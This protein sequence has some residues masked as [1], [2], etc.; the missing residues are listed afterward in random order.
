MSYNLEEIH[1][2]HVKFYS[3]G[4]LRSKV[5][6]SNAD[7]YPVGTADEEMTRGPRDRLLF[8]EEGK[9]PVFELTRAGVLT[10]NA[11]GE[12]WDL[13]STSDLILF[14]PEIAAKLF[15]ELIE[16]RQK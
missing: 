7:D 15:G 6:P 14:D 1:E 9:Q 11:T 4:G 8:Y 3:F 12:T 16:G 2:R 10:Y 5:E 13:N